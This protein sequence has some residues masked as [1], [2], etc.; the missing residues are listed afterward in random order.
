M[1]TKPL[2]RCHYKVTDMAE[3]IC[4]NC[5]RKIAFFKGQWWH[6]SECGEGDGENTYTSISLRKLQFLNSETKQCPQC[7]KENEV[8]EYCRNP[9]PREDDIG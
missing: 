6:T 2:Y 3:E 7:G 5:K 8:I 1:Q 4:K 9:E